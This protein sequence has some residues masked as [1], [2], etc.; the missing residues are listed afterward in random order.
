MV[1]TNLGYD[2]SLGRSA[3]TNHV[4][5]ALKLEAVRNGVA[6]KASV[7]YGLTTLFVDLKGNEAYPEI[8][9]RPR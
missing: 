4:A 3:A 5:P 1:P 7:G 6:M 9:L 8:A 2:A